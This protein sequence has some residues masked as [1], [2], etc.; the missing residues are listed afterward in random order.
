MITVVLLSK[1]DYSFPAVEN[2]DSGSTINDEDSGP[3]VNILYS[4]PTVEDDDSYR[5]AEL[6]ECGT[7]NT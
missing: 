2:D 7:N 3:I 4:G 6:D 5:A 1:A